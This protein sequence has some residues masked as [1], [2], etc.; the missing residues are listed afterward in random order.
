MKNDRQ[1]KTQAAGHDVASADRINE[2]QFSWLSVRQRLPFAIATLAGLTLAGGC[3]TRN[4]S[5]ASYSQ[6]TTTAYAGPAPAREIAQGDLVVPLHQ[7]SIRVDKREVDAGSVRLKKIVKTET[8]NQP[9][10]LRHEELV[11]DRQAGTGEEAKNK[12]LAEPFKEEETVIRLK[13]EEATIAKQTVPAGQIVVQTRSTAEQTNVQAQIRREDIDIARLGNA[14]NVTIGK[15]IRGNFNT[16]AN[17]GGAETPG[18]KATGTVS[19]SEQFEII[20]DPARLPS[21][22]AATYV[23]RP[24]HFKGMKVRKVMGDRLL[25]VSTD[26]G[27][28]LYAVCSE[29]TATAHE[30]DVV[31]IKGKIKTRNGSTTVTGLDEKGSQLLMTQP[32]YIEVEKIET[33]P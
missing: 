9:I 27:R 13:R 33:A 19:S 15:N 17:A 16:T 10:E 31:I 2:H 5:Q 23:G 26:N 24:V 12:A 1:T 25:V 7:E 11:I 14:Q 18:S 30:G 29:K 32:Y 22:N 8:V 20:T 6:P 3:C 21:D 4:A 28:P